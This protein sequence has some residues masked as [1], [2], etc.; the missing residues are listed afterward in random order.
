MSWADVGQIATAA[1]ISAGGIGAIIIGA[2]H[3]SANQIADRLSKSYESKLAQELEKYK[4]DL[5]KK[6]YVSKTRFDTEFQ[7]YQDLSVVFFDLIKIINELIPTKHTK[8]PA[9]KQEREKLEDNQ[10]DEANHIIVKAQDTLN[11]NAPFIPET[12]Y[13]SYDSILTKCFMQIYVLEQRYSVDNQ[14]LDRGK[15]TSIDYERMDEI[16]QEFRKNNKAI[17]EYLAS[18][19]VME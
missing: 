18:L 13:D 5:N 8:K 7:I 16:V 2:V 10:I 3:F 14:N 12:F 4:F 6:E 17:R 9:N 19:D 15:P 11:K 1:I